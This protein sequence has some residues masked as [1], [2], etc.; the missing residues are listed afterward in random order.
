LTEFARKVTRSDVQSIQSAEGVRRLF[1][2]L[3]YRV[4]PEALPVD[5]D[6]LELRPA[7][8]PV[9]R[10]FH[11]LGDYGFDLL[12]GLFVLDDLSGTRLRSLAGALLA[13]ST[14]C[15]FVAA[16]PEYRTLAVVNPRRLA[17]GKIKILKLL[18]DR[19]QPTRHDLD[20]LNEITATGLSTERIVDTHL[21]AFN[22][23]RITKAFYLRYRELF[24]GLRKALKANNRGIRQFQEDNEEDKEYLHAF[25]QRIMGRLMFLYFIQKK[26]WLDGDRRFLDNQFHRAHRDKLNFYRDVLEP[27]FF[28]TLNLPEA[29]RTDRAKAFG[30]VPY[31]NGGLFEKDY[32]FLIHLDNKLFSPDEEDGLLCFFNNYNFT[33]T[34][35]TP[36]DVE[37]ALDP[38][39][40]GKVFENLLAEQE[41]KAKGTFYTPRVIVHAMCRD[42]LAEYLADAAGL[43]PEAATALLADPEDSHLTV[44][45]AG[46][47]EKALDALRCLDPAVGSGA[48]LVGMLQEMIGLKLA[49]A[50]AKQ[51]NIQPGS[52]FVADWKRHFIQDCLYGVD[53]KREA[54]EIAKLRLW[55]SIVVDLERSQVQPLPNLDYKLMDGNSLVET[56]GGRPILRNPNAPAA[57]LGLYDSQDA[58]D[59]LHALQD[60]F[61]QA[62]PGEKKAI[63]EQIRALET[64][65]LQSHIQERRDD[66]A[67]RVKNPGAGK[68]A[69]TSRQL[70]ALTQE[71]DAL[72]QLSRDVKQGRPLPFFLY[73]LHF[74]HVFKDKGGFDVVIANPPYIATQGVNQLNYKDDLEA[75]YGYRRDLYVHFVDRALGLSETHAQPLLR[76][77]GILAVITSSTWFSQE[78]FR[79][80]RSGAPE[81][82]KRKEGEAW[83]F[84]RGILGLRLLK[85]LDCP[86]VFD[87]T[88]NTA[89]VIARNEPA[90]EAHE[91]LFIGAARLDQALRRAHNIGGA[92]L[93]A[94]VQESLEALRPDLSGAKEHIADGLRVLRVLRRGIPVYRLPLALYHRCVFQGVFEPS[95]PLLAF[96]DK[97][98]RRW[99]ETVEREFQVEGERLTLWEMVQSSRDIAKYEEP[100]TAY[101]ES[102]QPGDVTILGAVTEGG[103]GLATADNGRFLAYLEGTPEARML[104]ESNGEEGVGP[105]SFSTPYRGIHRIIGQNEVAP[106]RFWC[107]E[108]VRTGIPE[109]KAHW[110]PFAQGDPEG[111][112]WIRLNNVFID[113]SEASAQWLFANSGKRGANMPVVRNPHL[114]FG[115]GFCW[116][117]VINLRSPVKARLL[118]GSILS[119]ESIFTCSCTASA[120]TE[121]WLAVLNSGLMQACVR[122]FARSPQKFEVSHAK[123]VPLPI[124]TASQRETIEAAVGKAI[125]IQT[126]RLEAWTRCKLA[127]ERPD[128]D[129]DY[130]KHDAALKRV[131][132]EIDKLVADLYG[133]PVP[134]DPVEELAESL[135]EE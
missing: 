20:I 121:V 29:Q 109:R 32:D 124:P 90:P 134:A 111:N 101:R 133:L 105:G 61:F 3:G 60:G 43:G 126:Q 116:N 80:F 13:R 10:G 33:V 16:D 77:G 9:V 38:E 53:I 132:G 68:K 114:Y 91:F 100:L 22:V 64:E 135:A 55:L 112:R 110:V 128:A 62:A 48:F 127:G 120:P 51:A 27:L 41:R 83:P 99:V 46:A 79:Q 122:P 72:D 69:L 84:R 23:D 129:R 34:E 96:Y 66:I 56:L 82:P 103:Q 37:V 31:L 119:T 59:K 24:D 40:L 75:Q 36:L 88:V 2:Q 130:L 108:Y 7:D 117:R 50:R 12:L 98:M 17:P 123:I 58:L 6:E 93:D 28:E 35:D 39:M 113:W 21:R 63:Q 102:L 131:E 94:R 104:R 125:D 1:A 76:P 73:S 115:S 45:Q 44:A 97:Y 70:A 67:G 42:A 14:S 78:F 89:V 25:A 106:E 95:P 86:P 71:L 54:I 5:L 30:D 87:A 57:T 65:F 26:G 52:A 11:L 47:V 8:R 19:A 74:G 85:I 81:P 4:Q 118:A 92:D 107:Q 49:C 18:I 15:L